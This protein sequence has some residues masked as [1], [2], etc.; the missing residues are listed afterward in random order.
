MKATSIIC[1]LKNPIVSISD[2]GITFQSL[3]LKISHTWKIETGFQEKEALV[4]L[5]YAPFCLVNK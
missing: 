5:N 4:P 2:N 1:F 3:R